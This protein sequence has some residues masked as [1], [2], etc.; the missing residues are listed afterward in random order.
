MIFKL[1]EW[2]LD[3]SK[4]PFV[5]CNYNVMYAEGEVYTT[6]HHG[7]VPGENYM[8]PLE[9]G[10]DYIRMQHFG[11]DRAHYVV[12]NGDIQLEEND[13]YGLVSEWRDKSCPRS[14][15]N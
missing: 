5:E 15:R 9:D 12:Y 6:V 1:E 3:H 14:V 10:Y 11:K 4:H 8:I 13:R 2:A 7:L